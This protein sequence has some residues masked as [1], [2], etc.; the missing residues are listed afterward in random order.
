MA[1]SVEMQPL[2]SEPSAGF[3]QN[4]GFM[5]APRADRR[6]QGW[7]GPNFRDFTS[8]DIGASVDF[9]RQRSG[10][11]LPSQNYQ[12]ITEIPHAVSDVPAATQLRRPETEQDWE[13]QRA[14]I[15][16]L[17]W[18][19][20]KDLND[21]IEIMQQQYRFLATQKQYK[22]R[23]KRWKIEKNIKTSES[24]AM[25]RIQKQRQEHEGRSTTFILRKRKVPP[26]KID[27]FAKRQKRCEDGASPVS[28]PTPADLTYHTPP[29]L[30][31]M[32]SP[33]IGL[34]PHPLDVPVALDSF[35]PVSNVP[36]PVASPGRGWYD[37]TEFNF[38][39]PNVH[40]EIVWKQSMNLSV[41]ASSPP[42]HLVQPWILLPEHINDTSHFVQSPT[43]HT[44]D[45]TTTGGLQLVHRSP[46]VDPEY[47]NVELSGKLSHSNLSESFETAPYHIPISQSWV[48]SSHVNAAFTVSRQE[49]R[50]NKTIAK[51]TVGELPTIYESRPTDVMKASG[52]GLPEPMSAAKLRQHA[53]N[54][55]HDEPSP[56]AKPH[57]DNGSL[58]MSFKPCHKIDGGASLLE[59][60]S[61]ES[62]AKSSMDM[63][64]ELSNT[65]AQP[66]IATSQPIV[67]EG[68]A[69]ESEATDLV[70]MP[71][72]VY[73][74]S[75]MDPGTP[76]GHATPLRQGLHPGSN[77]YGSSHDDINEMDASR[78]IANDSP[79]SSR[80][81]SDVYAT[82][83]SFAVEDSAT[84]SE[85]ESDDYETPMNIIMEDSSN[86]SEPDVDNYNTPM[87][88]TIVD[89]IITS[90]PELYSDDQPTPKNIAVEHSSPFSESAYA[91]PM[92]IAII[93]SVT[94]SDKFFD[95]EILPIDVIEYQHSVRL[96]ATA[97]IPG[98]PIEAIERRLR[99]A[100]K[101]GDLKSVEELL[102]RGA[103]IDARSNTGMSALHLAA[104]N[105]HHDVLAFLL[106]EG[107]KL[108][109]VDAE[110]EIRLTG[111]NVMIP[112]PHP[113][114]LAALRGHRQCTN[115][116]LE[117][118]VSWAVPD[119]EG[120][121]DNFVDLLEIAVE[122]NHV[123]L[124][125]FVI[126]LRG[127]K[128][129]E[130]FD[131][132]PVRTAAHNGS[133]PLVSLFLDRGMPPNMVFEED[134]SSLWIALA[135]GH[136]PIVDH[137][138][139]H[140]AEVN[141]RDR[142][143]VSPLDAAIAQG[144]G[145]IAKSLLDKGAWVNA[146]GSN[147]NVNAEAN[148]VDRLEDYT[149][150]I[151][152]LLDALQIKMDDNYRTPLHLAVGKGR[153]DIVSI[154]LQNGASP[155]FAREKGLI[156]PIQMAAKRGHAGILQTFLNF[157]ADASWTPLEVATFKGCAATVKVLLRNG[158]DPNLYGNSRQPPLHTAIDHDFLDIAGLLLE[159]GADVNDLSSSH[160]TPLEIAV[161]NKSYNTVKLLLQKGA[162]PSAFGNNRQTPL[163]IAIGHDSWNIAE[164]LLE[165]GADPNRLDSSGHSPFHN[166]IMLGNSMMVNLLLDD[167]ADVN[168]HTGKGL[169]VLDLALAKESYCSSKIILP[170]LLDYDA[171][172]AFLLP[173]TAAMGVKTAVLDNLVESF[174][175]W[176]L[177]LL[178][179]Q[180]WHLMHLAS[181]VGNERVLK[182]LLQSAKSNQYLIRIKSTTQRKETPLHVAA[183]A[184]HLG[185][186]RLLANADRPVTRI[187]DANLDTALHVAVKSSH[188]DITEELF[189]LG[190]I[191][192][193]F[194]YKNQELKLPNHVSA[195]IQS[196]PLAKNLLELLF[197]SALYL[198]DHGPRKDQTG[199]GIHVKNRSAA[200]WILCKK[201]DD[202]AL[203]NE[204]LRLLEISLN[205]GDEALFKML[206]E[207]LPDME[208]V[209][210][211]LDKRMLSWFMPI[212]D[213]SEN[214]WRMCRAVEAFAEKKVDLFCHT[215]RSGW[216][217]LTRAAFWGDKA[218]VELGFK[219]GALVDKTDGGGRTAY[220]VAVER[221]HMGVQELLIKARVMPLRE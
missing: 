38:Q 195:I 12:P 64:K 220:D 164:L 189:R 126:Q 141:R 196:S 185:A 152:E 146:H 7:A 54:D 182:S 2:L 155:A 85:P 211:G 88:S 46:R 168:V 74:D 120:R 73:K 163:H 157:T 117:K 188:L 178:E 114:H 108:N 205:E 94:V 207:I 13:D 21:V 179:L 193:Q 17:Y 165:H 137:L 37:A 3:R 215:A 197:S 191:A 40:P 187:V 217:M 180:S 201:H 71:K 147:P 171:D 41:R 213:V 158:S 109:T 190:G 10:V 154:L 135:R 29:Q 19:Q 43:S 173:C 127:D 144:H 122:S 145:E 72:A 55:D 87:D 16:E 116:V 140:D 110:M 103:N 36:T 113:I 132:D 75:E 6:L 11:R 23:I 95:D 35:P 56:A 60:L 169:S 139:K 28:V 52:R 79:A 30:D 111:R 58:T 198:R 99:F 45:P 119:L 199:I 183:R 14:R 89:K 128:W 81:G 204:W 47:I 92:E 39:I 218:M 123:Q 142:N 150:S 53:S 82:P 130:E 194:T 77:N 206:V 112:N 90:E 65:V 138:L 49:F 51:G 80:T 76:T 27:R 42:P 91:T 4:Q 57:L 63:V 25:I 221:K 210:H 9:G 15:T 136:R 212:Y 24:Q 78:A 83:M 214:S 50:P 107:A 153:E 174:A 22:L 66:V 160:Q 186:V 192:Y 68:S 115:I 62:Q 203:E 124:A 208:A 176:D 100:A 143:G 106:D 97:R 67:S 125:A 31:V 148:G 102:H 177:G 159:N 104:Y 202:G 105:G 161:S 162:D 129:W 156:S 61:H 34:S 33:S 48:G 149:E 86:S 170:I 5:D 18:E 8:D 131:L 209:K 134:I 175:L 200:I 118:T 181:G 93:D 98:E 219:F 172:P 167:N 151:F 96:T 44:F 32:K 184:G 216:N 26:E 84:D 166:A 20:D 69:P 133:L 1:R 70:D 59:I 101:V 121:D